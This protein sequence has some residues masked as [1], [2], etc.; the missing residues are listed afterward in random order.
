M[1][2]VPAALAAA[3]AVV[4]WLSLLGPA[5][6]VYGNDPGAAR[7]SLRENFLAPGSTVFSL[8]AF[9]VVPAALAVWASLRRPGPVWAGIAALNAVVAITP[10]LSTTMYKIVWERTGADG[11]SMS[12]FGVA[13]ATVWIL[14]L[15]AGAVLLGLAALTVPCPTGVTRPSRIALS[16]T[17]GL[18][19]LAVVL[20]HRMGFTPDVPVRALFPPAEQFDVH[21][22]GAFALSLWWLAGLL[23][24]VTAVAGALRPR[25][26]IAVIL[27]VLAAAMLPLNA[28][29]L[30]GAASEVVSFSTDR[31]LPGPGVLALLFVPLAAITAAV[32]QLRSREHATGDQVA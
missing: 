16:V 26:V 1:R 25:R 30:L 7:Y 5:V 12:G 10:A 28:L 27:C 22:G 14:P 20:P 6:D 32:V 23:L 4:P 9:L 11:S 31:E 2:W 15:L 3:A 18:C 13:V 21:T 8:L 17:G 29:L 24:V 19:L